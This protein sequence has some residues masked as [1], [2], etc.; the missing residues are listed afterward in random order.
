MLDNPRINFAISRRGYPVGVNHLGLQVDSAKE[1]TAMRAQLAGADHAL[2]EQT[3]AACCYAKAD[4]YW[5]HG[6]DRNRVGDFS[7]SRCDT[8]LRRGYRRCAESWR[9]LRAVEGNVGPRIWLRLPG[10]IAVR[11]RRRLTRVY[12]L[13]PVSGRSGPVVAASSTV[14]HRITAYGLR[15]GAKDGGKA[16][17]LTASGDVGP[18]GT[19]LPGCIACS[20]E[21][22]PPAIACRSHEYRVVSTASSCS[23][24]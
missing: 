17:V 8:D 10:T 13:Q 9:V 16:V 11:R 19:S 6:S 3:G 18:W 12:I 14:A 4:K 20:P 22:R 2:V 5:M 1:V 24:Y 7:H 21:A 15:W 23:S